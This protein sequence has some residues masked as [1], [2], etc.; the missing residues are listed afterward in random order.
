MTHTQN[1]R[2]LAAGRTDTGCIRQINE[3]AFHL[4]TSAG[5]LVVADGMGGHN[6]GEV[7]SQQVVTSIGQSLR[8]LAL[9]PQRAQHPDAPDK[10]PG[11]THEDAPGTR[12][13]TQD[14]C[15]DTPQAGGALPEDTS[16]PVAHAVR[17]VVDQVNTQL[18]EINQ[19]NGLSSQKGMGSTLVAL[20]MSEACEKPVVFHVGDSRLYR[21]HQGQLTLMTC[22]HSMYQRW[23]HSGKQGMPPPRNIL[24]KAMGPTPKV[25]PDVRFLNVASGDVVLL[26]SDGLT[27][28]VEEA[29]ILKT[30]QEATPHTL[31][32]VCDR[33]IEMARDAG[34]RDN[35]TVIVGYFL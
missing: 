14:A 17:A 5:L 7:A 29:R 13:S 24:F 30:L 12:P 8:D 15:A 21:L 1:R 34:G 26:C 35:I 28:M 9:Q 6:A 16:H 22:D 11:N 18:Y 25:T 32:A 23:A 2:L 31:K 20:W 19:A 33:L 4:D 3:D 10:S 27:G